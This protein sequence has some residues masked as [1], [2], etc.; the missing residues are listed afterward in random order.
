MRRSLAQGVL[1]SRKTKC[2]PRWTFLRQYATPVEYN[3][4]EKDPQLGDYPQLPFE[5]TQLRPAKGWWD[6]QM[7]RNYGEIHE[8]DD[9][10]NM[11]TPD[12]PPPVPPS[13]ALRQF[14]I[15]ALG[16]AAFGYIVYHNVP[17]RSAI[18]REYP[19][20][21]LVRELGGLEENKA[22]PESEAEED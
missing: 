17:E 14:S 9:G 20:G 13:V 21:G 16:I 10:L 6:L 22:I 8:E 18:P 7:R 11:W 3:P 2:L 1:R 4:S 5:S 12:A 15:A 19:F